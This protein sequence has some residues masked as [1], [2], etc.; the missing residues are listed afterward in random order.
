M[1]IKN[2][3]GGQWGLIK[4]KLDFFTLEMAKNHLI[5]NFLR[6]GR[7][8]VNQDVYQNEKNKVFKYRNEFKERIRI[9]Y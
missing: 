2:L 6:N 7:L 5:C 8:R 9:F 3:M 1:R 4:K